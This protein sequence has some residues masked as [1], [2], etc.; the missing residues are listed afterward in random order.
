MM[1]NTTKFEQRQQAFQQILER[2]GVPCNL[3]KSV[4]EILSLESFGLKEERTEQEQ[5]L[6][7]SAW[8]WKFANEMRGKH[9]S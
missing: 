5:Y 4:S 1:I 8:Q 6:V 9:E 3:A 7:T 2:K